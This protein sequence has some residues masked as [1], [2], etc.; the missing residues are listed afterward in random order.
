M[1]NTPSSPAHGKPLNQ[2]DS[3]REVRA[4]VVVIGGG[5][6]GLAAA[7]ALGRSRRRVLVVD[8]DEPRNAPS[9]GAHNVLG[10]EGI[11][12][13]EI[14]RRGRAEASTYGVEF[15]TGVAT[16]ASGALD[17]F[18]VEVNKGER[19]VH[20][21]RIII[22]TG[23]VDDL[24]ELPGVREGWGTSVLH[25]AFCHGWE[26]RDQRIAV[27]AR[28]EIPVHQVMLFRQL[29]DHVTLFLHDAPEPT[30]DEWQQLAALGARAVTPR[31]T[32][33]DTEGTQLRAIEVEGGLRFDMDAAVVTPRYLART[34]LYRSL[35]GEPAITPHGVQIPTDPRGATPLAGVF[36]AGNASAIMAMVTASAA[37]G[38]QIGAA[39]HGDLAF[40]DLNAAVQERLAPFSAAMEAEN[41]ELVLGDRRHGL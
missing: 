16:G 7:I 8:A 27:I 38:V 34:E 19:F 18:T 24:P 32:R 33:L 41:C 20:A 21:R 35:G 39:V 15:V 40:A 13:A 29:S 26:V 5:P 25:C 14:L 3:S 17:D 4:D 36:A 6:A 11:T 10:Q 23:L 22:A 30:E 1:N 28:D 37:A 9:P 12:P 31:I 2:E